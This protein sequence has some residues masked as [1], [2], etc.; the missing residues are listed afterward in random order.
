[1]AKMQLSLV[2]L[3]TL[4]LGILSV[5]LIEKN[6]REKL[7]KM[8]REIGWV[9][10]NKFTIDVLVSSFSK[11]IMNFVIHGCITLKDA[12]GKNMGEVVEFRLKLPRVLSQWNH[13]GQT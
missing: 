3:Y 4:K 13:T 9:R 7:P 5:I 10:T 6:L 12:K 11:S 2:I 8:E 1:M